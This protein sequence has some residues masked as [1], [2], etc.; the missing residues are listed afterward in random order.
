LRRL[1]GS[2][3]LTLKWAGI[4]LI[5]VLAGSLVFI[6]LSP[7]RDLG[8][9]VSKVIERHRDVSEVREGHREGVKDWC[10]PRD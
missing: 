1:L 9:D 10:A 3:H 4:L 8:C 2:S 6:W 5:L 7:S